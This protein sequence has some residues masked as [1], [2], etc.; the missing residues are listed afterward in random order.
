MSYKLKP[1]DIFLIIGNFL[2]PIYTLF[3]F[4]LTPRSVTNF[5]FFVFVTCAI[6]ERGWETFKTSKE[7]KKDELHGDWTLVAVTSTYIILFFF[8]VTEFYLKTKPFN[9]FITAVGIALLIASFRL[10]LW[11]MSAL[12]KQW[13]VHAVGAQKIRKVRLLRIGPYRYIRHPIYLGIMVEELSFPI[14]ANA[15][16]SLLFAVFVC[17][18]LVIIR[19]C[20]EEKTSL[21]RFGDKYL[22]FKRQVGMF[23]PTQLLKR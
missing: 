6:V 2:I 13:A 4:L 12:G 23:F 21:R 10:R 15:F 18:P 11:G 5:L 8:F 16:Y 19:A 1:V 17:L 20:E 14:I 22:D 7:R 9:P 3:L